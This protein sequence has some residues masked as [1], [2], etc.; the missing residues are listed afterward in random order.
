MLN[1]NLL[2]VFHEVAEKR[3]VA[4][5]AATLFVSQPAVSN[6]LKRLQ[7]DNGVNLFYK[8]GRNLTLTE[9]GQQLYALTTQLFS[10]E[11]KIENFLCGAKSKSEAS[12]RIGLATIY[13]RFGVPEIKKYFAEI[14][15]DIAISVCSGNSRAL[16]KRFEE[17]AVDMA[18]VGDIIQEPHF[19][20]RFYKKHH[21]YLVVPK[22]HRLY[23]KSEF[24]HTDLRGE[25]MVFKEVGS[26]VRKAVDAYQETFRINPVVIME[27]SNIDAIFHL[28]MQEKCLTLLPDLSISLQD[29]TKKAFSIARC[30]DMDLGFSTHIIWHAD[31]SQSEATRTIIEKFCAIAASAQSGA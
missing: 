17:H 16:L 30:T 6:A 8:V 22:G 11:E 27:L 31:G 7:Q 19:N 10:L 20:Y 29:N 12:I 15:N 2:R 28:I 3:G 13:E 1:L 4:R 5:A 24:S 21:I 9:Q 25:R 14:S 23:G 18:I 26:S